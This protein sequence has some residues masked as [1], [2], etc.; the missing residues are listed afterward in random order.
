MGPTADIDIDG[1]SV[2]RTTDDADRRAASEDT[3]AA[4][5]RVFGRNHGAM[6]VEI[7]RNLGVPEAE[8]IRALPDGRS[9]ELDPSRW[10]EI[11]R[12]FEPLGKVHVICTN[13][14]C[15]MEVVGSFGKFSRSGQYFNVQ[16]GSL[17]MHVRWKTL[18]H[19]FAVEKPGHMD[20]VSTVSFQLFSDDGRAAF[21]V[22][23]TF[24]GKPPTPERRAAFER[25]RDEFRL[26]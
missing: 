22:F 16:N 21:K 11:L 1:S 5:R 8:V 24:G 14:A 4:V 18:R 10:E 25:L 7:A 13:A 23:L 19:I 15:T 26:A 9:V 12:A 3:A 2:E 6:T 17:D 20:G